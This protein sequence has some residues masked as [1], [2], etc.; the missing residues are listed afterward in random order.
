MARDITWS[1]NR[2]EVRVGFDRVGEG[3]TILLLPALS[4][5]STRQEMRP[6]QERLASEFSAE[7]GHETE[8]VDG[9]ALVADLILKHTTHALSPLLYTRSTIRK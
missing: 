7:R 9:A 1:W 3:S 2:E 8:L 4:S 5:V 6:L